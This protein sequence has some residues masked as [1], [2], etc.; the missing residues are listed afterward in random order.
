MNVTPEHGLVS[1]GPEVHVVPC[2]LTGRQ[3]GTSG[4]PS[5]RSVP[6]R[7]HTRKTT[8]L[9]AHLASADGHTPKSQRYTRRALLTHPIKCEH[10]TDVGATQASGKKQTVHEQ[11]PW[12][13]KETGA[14]CFSRGCSAGLGTHQRAP[15]WSLGQDRE[16][17]PARGASHLAELNLQQPAASSQ[18][19]P[20]GRCAGFK[21]TQDPMASR[22]GRHPRGH[23]ADTQ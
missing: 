18:V 16:L 21:N 10:G 15:V 9:P 1:K 13:L 5:Q 19:W 2:H 4:E 14:V 22:A 8:P 12:S 17:L 20:T 23:V 7:K 6:N 11:L 3:N